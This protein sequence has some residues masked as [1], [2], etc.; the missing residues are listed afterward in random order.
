MRTRRHHVVRRSLDEAEVD[1]SE[2]EAIFDYL[3]ALSD[4]SAELMRKL[5]HERTQH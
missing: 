4:A 2:R 3:Q 5:K 1:E